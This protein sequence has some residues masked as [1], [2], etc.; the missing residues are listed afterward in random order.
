MRREAKLLIDKACD[1]L[2]LGIELY[3]RPNDRGRVSGVL[4][5]TNHAF[6]MLLKA[7]IVHNGGRIHDRGSK[8][9]I[10]FDSCVRRG[11]SDGSIKFVID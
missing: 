5:L 10:G 4:I 7:A 11:T 2:L 6:E 3:N 8:E 9:T 1:S